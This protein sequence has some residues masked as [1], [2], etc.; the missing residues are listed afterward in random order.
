MPKSENLIRERVQLGPEY[1]ESLH[2]Q[3]KIK[4]KVCSHD[5]H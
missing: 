3:T 4:A 5:F 2:E 1:V